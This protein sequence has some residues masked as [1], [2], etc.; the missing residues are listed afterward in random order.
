MCQWAMDQPC[1][2][3]FACGA[4]CNLNCMHPWNWRDHCTEPACPRATKL[5]KP[6]FR[7]GCAS[8]ARYAQRR[9]LTM[10]ASETML[11]S[12]CFDHFSYVTVLRDPVARLSSQ[13]ERMTTRPNMKLRSLLASPYV[14]NTSERTSLMGTAAVDNYLTRLLLGPPAF[15]LPLRGINESHFA[16]AAATLASFT[17][18]IPIE[19]L[20]G[21]GSRVL[22][23]LLGW[24]G[25]PRRYNGHRHRS[26]SAAAGR[27]GTSGRGGGSVGKG[28]GS[29]GGHAVADG[30]GNSGGGAV[31][32]S[33]FL[34]TTVA[35]AGWHQRGVDRRAATSALDAGR[36]AGRRLASPT[37]P[38]RGLG[39]RSIKLLRQLNQY[40]Y[41]LLDAARARLAAQLAQLPNASGLARESWRRRHC[42][43]AL[44][45]CSKGKQRW[46]LGL[47]TRHKST[48][49]N[50]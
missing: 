1:S 24:G 8:L 46:S 44:P 39:E 35:H 38:R 48:R 21:A 16:A 42:I 14:F 12:R 34:P 41:R 5:C 37:E 23:H 30:D 27:G 26:H 36:L 29:A 6:P 33:S 40:D 19:Q 25:T 49:V 47:E 2:R 10:L 50:R 28:R 11:H 43:D 4:N 7:P 3:V 15:F 9:N 17:A 13:L 31:P 22:A 32:F 20:D 18:A 45:Q